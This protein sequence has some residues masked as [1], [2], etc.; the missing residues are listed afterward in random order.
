LY[1][2]TPNLNHRSP[3]N[4]L[5]NSDNNLDDSNLTEKLRSILP[6]LN[7]RQQRLGLA[8]EARGLGYGGVTHQLMEL[9]HL[10]KLKEWKTWTTCFLTPP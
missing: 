5:G 3:S 8:A 6:Y 2:A 9:H 10:T 1:L 4:Q 7:E